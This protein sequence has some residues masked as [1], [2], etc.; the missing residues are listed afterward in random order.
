M[1][2]GLAP[3]ATRRGACPRYARRTLDGLATRLTV[4]GARAVPGTARLATQEGLDNLRDGRDDLVGVALGHG[5]GSG[6]LLQVRIADVDQRRL[7][8][9][10]SHAVG[11]CHLGD[12]ASLGHLLLKL[13]LRDAEL[14]GRGREQV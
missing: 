11:R 14:L 8:R 10:V 9:R 6:G 2:A 5:A 3:G 1:P 13:G 4:E 12:A 7:D